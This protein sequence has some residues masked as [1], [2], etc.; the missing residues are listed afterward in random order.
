M[1]S[2]NN[3]STN[4]MVSCRTLLLDLPSFN[5]TDNERNCWS[6]GQKA[7]TVYRTMA[8]KKN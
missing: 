3:D 5:I 8:G 4:I 7:L 2:N 1:Y 6:Q